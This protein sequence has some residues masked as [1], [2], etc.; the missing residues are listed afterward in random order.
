MDFVRSYFGTNEPLTSWTFFPHFLTG[1]QQKQ[2]KIEGKCSTGQRFVCTKETSYK[3]H[4]LVN[5]HGP[6]I[7]HCRNRHIDR[8]I[9]KWTGLI[10]LCEIINGHA[11]Y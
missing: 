6:I 7:G 1:L 11:V 5:R 9:V 10:F 8:K 3:I 2:T 4:T